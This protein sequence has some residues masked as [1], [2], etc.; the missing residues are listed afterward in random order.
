MSDVANTKESLAGEIISELDSIARDV[1]IYEYGLPIHNDE[2]I[3]RMKAA[4]IKIFA[5]HST[6]Q[7]VGQEGK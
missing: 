5:R 2:A 1:D 6:E 7:A 3:E 4:I